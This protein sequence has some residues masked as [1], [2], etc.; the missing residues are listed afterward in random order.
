MAFGEFIEAVNNGKIT[1]SGFTKL[2]NLRYQRRKLS[3]KFMSTQIFIQWW[4]AWASHMAIDFRQQCDGSGDN[5]EILACNGTKVGI[6][7]KNSF[8]ELIEQSCS[9]KILETKLKR[10]DRYFSLSSRKH[11]C[12]LH[13]YAQSSS[14]CL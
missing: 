10:L 9:S 12:I 7:F 3:A 5:P 1:F 14:R 2:M 13:P 6:G 4:F 8:V 11:T